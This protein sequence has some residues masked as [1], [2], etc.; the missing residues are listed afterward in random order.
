MVRLFLVLVHLKY[1]YRGI[2]II[3]MYKR[4]HVFAFSQVLLHNM[5][6][7]QLWGWPFRLHNIDFKGPTLS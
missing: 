5:L 6:Y 3:I 7:A 2:Y 4:L 1:N